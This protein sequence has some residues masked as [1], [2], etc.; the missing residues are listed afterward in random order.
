MSID[1]NDDDKVYIYILFMGKNNYYLTHPSESSEVWPYLQH[2]LPVCPV[3]S[4]QLLQ[5]RQHTLL[6]FGQLGVVCPLL[7]QDPRLLHGQLLQLGVHPV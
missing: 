2:E 6:V 3:Q 7:V 4:S 1:T 5:L